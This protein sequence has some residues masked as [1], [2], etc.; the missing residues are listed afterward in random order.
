MKITKIIIPITMILF[1]LISC[2]NTNTQSTMDSESTRFNNLGFTF[3]Q[4]YL[5]NDQ[6]SSILDSA[7]YYFNRAI[8]EDETNMAAHQNKNAVLFEQKKYDEIIVNINSYLERTNSDDYQTKAKLYESMANTYH[9]KGDFV[10]EQSVILKAKHY[11]QLG[12]KGPLNESFID[13]YILFIAHTAG[14]DTALIELEK[15]KDLLINSIPYEEF[16]ECL[17]LDDFSIENNIHF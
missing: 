7:L 17:I 2:C 15:Y 5:F 12:L 14:K 11:Y 8:A 1:H 13:D 3:W 6:D 9:L 4:E 10:S 16:K